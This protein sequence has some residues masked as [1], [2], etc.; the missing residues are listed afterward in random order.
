MGEH[1]KPH[2]IAESVSKGLYL[3]EPFATNVRYGVL[4]ND[5]SKLYHN[6]TTRQSAEWHEVR[7]KI[8]VNATDTAMLC[9]VYFVLIIFTPQFKF[10][11]QL[12]RQQN[13]MNGYTLVAPA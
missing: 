12:R 5:Q 4:M 13:K 2:Q 3:I 7:Q 1:G 8:K 10:K 11:W 6:H 9:I